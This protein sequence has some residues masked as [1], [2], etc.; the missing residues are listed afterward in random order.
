MKVVDGFDDTRVNAVIEAARESKEDSNV[1]DGRHIRGCSMMN[2]LD[3][4]RE[5]I[6]EASRSNPCGC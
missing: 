1:R 5:E 4:D 3:L 2:A 6:K